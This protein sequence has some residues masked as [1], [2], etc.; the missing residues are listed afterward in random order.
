MKSVL[1]DPTQYNGY[2]TIGRQYKVIEFTF[3]DFSGEEEQQIL[4]EA[5]SIYHN[6]NGSA[7]NSGVPR[8]NQTKWIDALSGIIS[9]FACVKFL[10]DERIFEGFKAH[11]PNIESIQNQVDIIW[12]M[13]ETDYSVEVRS[14][15][16]KNGIEF[17]LYGVNRET[18]KSYIDVLGPYYQKTYKENYENFKDIFLRVL[19][20]SE[21]SGF[22][23]RYISQKEPFYLV[24]GLEGHRIIELNSHK[25]LTPE[26]ATGLERGDYYVAQ[27]DEIMDSGEFWTH[28][29]NSIE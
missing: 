23:E 17:A 14:S 27:I 12:E 26:N 28:F 8:S 6:A 9:E 20:P 29:R 11:R 3:D 16:V 13:N 25:T 10:S 1:F 7:A 21:K 18:G 24:G 4:L 22:E 19:F 2:S 5:D 15:F